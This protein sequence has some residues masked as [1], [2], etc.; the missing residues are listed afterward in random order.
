MVMVT[1]IEDR[2]YAGVESLLSWDCPIG[3]QTSLD[4]GLSQL[5]KDQ[6]R[7]TIRRCFNEFNL[8]DEKLCQWEDSS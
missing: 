5:R 3:R 6:K 1:H 2:V 8:I 4:Y 7:V